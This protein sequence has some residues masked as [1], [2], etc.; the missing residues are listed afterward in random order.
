V[1]VLFVSSGNRSEG[2]SPIT[3]SQGESLMQQGV[4]VDFFTIK[5]KGIRSYLRHINIL[6]DY[7]KAKR[8]D[9]IHAHYSY[10]SYLATIVG[11]RPLVV[12]LMG[13]DIKLHKYSRFI[14]AIFNKLFWGK[15]IV[16][17]MDLCNSLKLKNIEIVPNGVNINHF[18][19]LD[20]KE[21]QDRL[22][23]KKG[24]KH[25]LFGSDPDRYEK[26]YILVKDSLN[27]LNENYKLT[28]HYLK[29]VQHN[30]I[31]YYLNAADVLLLSSFYEGSPNII[32]EAM[33]C[34]CPIVSTDVG[35][36]RQVLG[37]TEGCYIAGF[38]PED[39]S[40]NIERALNF[41]KRTNGRLYIIK[42]GLDSKSIAARI[43]EI[44][45][46]VTIRK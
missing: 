33:A 34:N 46:E 44:Y 31:I 4:D 3:K 15:T 5:G 25:V 16:K 40:K 12:S 19:Q 11:A 45:K 37:N 21:C 43:I 14:I 36:V 28:V 1:K 20:Q 8:F 22:E 27:L 6:R 38:E 26:N 7:I 39:Y 9:I 10:S 29:N 18:Y 42:L 24:E 35:D 41:K 23:W 30:D 17:S 32:K 2:I 13:S